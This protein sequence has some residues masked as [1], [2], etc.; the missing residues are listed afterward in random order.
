MKPSWLTIKRLALAAF[1][2]VAA[3]IAWGAHV[4]ENFCEL[5]GYWCHQRIKSSSI[6]LFRLPYL[7]KL[8]INLRIAPIR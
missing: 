1:T 6:P 8:L 3:A 2:G 5:S 7:K 4:R